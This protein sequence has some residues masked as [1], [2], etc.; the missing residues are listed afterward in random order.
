MTIKETKVPLRKLKR[1]CDGT[2]LNPQRGRS[3]NGC[4]PKDDQRMAE[5]RGTDRRQGQKF[6]AYQRKPLRT[7]YSETLR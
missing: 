1:V 5:V 3:H 2:S 4:S 7:V 6:V